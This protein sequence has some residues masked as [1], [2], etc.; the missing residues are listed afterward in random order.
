MSHS[1]RAVAR[2]STA[3]PAPHPQ[4]QQ[5]P[6]P[7]ISLSHILKRLKMCGWYWGELSSQQANDILKNSQDGSFILR[8][9]TDACHLF[10]LSLKANGY[11]I[12]VRVTFSR[13]QFKLDSCHQQD[14][15][16]FESV[17]ELIDYYLEND[18]REFY[19]TVPDIGEFPVSLR[20]P[21]W[22]EM[23][24]L[25]HLCRKCIVHSCKTP[26]SIHKLPLPQHLIRYLLEFA[27]EDQSGN[28]AE[29]SAL[30][31]SNHH[32]SSEA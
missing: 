4:Q 1:T 19:V 31:V 9:S 5:Q 32:P 7:R 25:H 8:D 15:P 13:G 12:S 17:V 27:P 26:A 3:R 16:S 24:S 21:I 18:C 11:V 30:V 14:C 28:S 10:T 2:P 29:M 22:K 6:V 20:H 23:P